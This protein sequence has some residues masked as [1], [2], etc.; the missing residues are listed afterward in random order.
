VRKF[1]TEILF[2]S[3][4]VRRAASSCDLQNPDGGWQ[5]LRPVWPDARSG[6]RGQWLEKIHHIVLNYR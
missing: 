1:G 4:A 5:S 6:M 2:G 3:V